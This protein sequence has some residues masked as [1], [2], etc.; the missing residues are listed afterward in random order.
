MKINESNVAVISDL[1]LGLHQASGMWHDICLNYAEWLKNELTG[2]VRDILILGDIID[3]RNE[4]AV[5]TL[6]ILYKF[7]K[8]LEDFNI[9]IITGNH[10]CYYSKRTDVHSIGT[11][12]DW[13]NIEVIDKLLSVNIF[14]RNLSFCP[15]STQVGDIPKSD[16]IFGHFE[17]NTFKMNG[18][19]VCEHGINAQALLEKAPLILT[20]HFHNTEERNYK[21]GRIIYVGS[22]YEQNWG[23][24]N[25]PKGYYMLDIHEGEVS[26]KENL[27]SPKHIKI[28]LSELI[29][30]G[31]TTNIKKEFH[32]NIIT[33]IVDAQLEQSMVDALLSKLYNLKPLSIRIDNQIFADNIIAADEDMDFEGVDIKRDILDFVNNL[34]DVDNKKEL[35]NYLTEVYDKC[36]EN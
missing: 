10:D 1:H 27:F 17:I 34:E 16:I 32:N 20:G 25:H 6:H 14:G 9:V 35:I 2:K 28:R 21:N 29:T 5:P 26:F 18:N 15:W 30:V 33:L 22:P 7:F 4:V 8:V 31:I 3:N 36:M 11:L 13:D 23:E 24:C 19:H 12:S